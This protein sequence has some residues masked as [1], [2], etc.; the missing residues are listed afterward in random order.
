MPGRAHFTILEDIA[1]PD[2]AIMDAVVEAVQ[3]MP[4]H[5]SR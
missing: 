5:T 4:K 1:T 3:G 2:S